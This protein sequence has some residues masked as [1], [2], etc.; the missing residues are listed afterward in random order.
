MM[1]MN[2][3]LPVANGLL[4]GILH[5]QTSRRSI[6]LKQFQVIMGKTILELLKNSTD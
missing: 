6:S 3:E 4:Q 2:Q 1:I 5:V